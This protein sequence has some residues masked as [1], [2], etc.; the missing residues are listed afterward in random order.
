MTAFS[1]GDSDCCNRAVTSEAYGCTVC[2]Q[3]TASTGEWLR[4]AISSA[5]PHSSH[6]KS[7]RS[8]FEIHK[9]LSRH[10]SAVSQTEFAQAEGLC[11]SK[12]SRYLSAHRV[13]AAPASQKARSHRLLELAPPSPSPPAYPGR[14]AHRVLLKTDVVLE[15]SGGF[16]GQAVGSGTSCRLPLD[17]DLVHPGHRPKRDQFYVRA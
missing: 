5:M 1:N 3:R 12:L 9:L 8:P 13:R 16:C 4:G 11:F 14:A 15:V 17:I 10:S 2:A 6:T 7:R